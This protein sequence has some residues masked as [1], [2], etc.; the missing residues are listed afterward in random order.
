MQT[1]IDKN[2]ARPGFKIP[3]ITLPVWFLC[4]A[5]MIALIWII[6]PFIDVVL[7]RHGTLGQQLFEPGI[8]EI[9]FRIAISALIIIFSII[10]SLFLIHSRRVAKGLRESQERLEQNYH[11]QN[12]MSNILHYSLRPVSL[13]EILKFSLDAILSEPV[14]SLKKKGSIFIA[15]DSNE[16]LMLEVHRGLDVAMQNICAGVPFGKCLCGRAASSREIIFSSSVDGRHENTYEG[17]LP[18]GHYCVPILSGDRVLGVINT[19][20]SAGHRN[21]Q[22]EAKF[23]TM[24]AD[25]LAGIIERKRGLN[26][27]RLSEEISQ[28]LLNSTGEAIYGVDLDGEFIFANKTCVKMLGY[29]DE[30]DLLGRNMHNL[31]HHSRADGTRYPLEKCII[32]QAITTGKGIHLD[33]VFWT[34]DGSS[35]FAECNSY[36]INR[37]GLVIGSVISFSDITERKNRDRELIESREHLRNLAKRLQEIR[38]EERT[39]IARE[40][41]DELGQTLTGLKMDLFWLSGRLPKNWKHLPRRA[42]EMISLIDSTINF[43]R[44]LSTEL[45]PSMLD[46]LGLKAAIE[47]QVQEFAQRTRCKYMLDLKIRDFSPDSDRDTAIFRIL[48]ESL[49][50]IARHAKADYVEISMNEIDS[51]LMLSI[52][53]NGIGIDKEKINSSSLGLISMRERAGTFGGEFSIRALAEGGSQVTLNIPYSRGIT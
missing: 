21:T 14:F 44:K 39:L 51:Q 47:W 34:A 17:M 5:V 18:H 16:M 28:L 43:V 32:H 13:G 11:L 12:V 7:L 6:D 25:T 36:P 23:L 31:I 29:R 27:L 42:Q 46:D 26:A 24:I 10:V 33:D 30:Q 3:D 40:I 19:Y 9:Y 22:E 35:F 48:Q 37:D 2:H 1:D 4:V 53:D 41:H 8:H 20:V 38:E 52:K 15:D 50:N 45:R 49:T